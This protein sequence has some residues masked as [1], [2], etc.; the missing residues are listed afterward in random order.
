MRIGH[1]TFENHY[2]GN[3][4]LAFQFEFMGIHNCKVALA[5]IFNPFTPKTFSLS[6]TYFSHLWLDFHVRMED[7]VFLLSV[8]KSKTS[9]NCVCKKSSHFHGIKAI[10]SLAKWMKGRIIRDN[11]GKLAKRQPTYHLLDSGKTFDFI[12]STV[13]SLWRILTIEEEDE[14]ELI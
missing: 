7:S 2:Y 5:F 8:L 1:Q 14:R 12:W 6:Q 13:G 11:Y 3:I 9:S 4:L 10:L